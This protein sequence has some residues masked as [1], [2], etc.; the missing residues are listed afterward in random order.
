MDDNQ[1]IPKKK[2]EWPNQAKPYIKSWKVW[3]KITTTLYCISG[4]LSIL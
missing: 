4:K 3:S 1:K 2:I